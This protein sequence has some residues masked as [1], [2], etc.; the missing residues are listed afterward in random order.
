[1]T[2]H[3]TPAGNSVNAVTRHRLLV[4]LVAALGAFV[5]Q[6][7]GP[8]TVQLAMQPMKDYFRE[9]CFV[10]DVGQQLTY[11][12]NTRHPVEFNLHHHR[13]DGSMSYPVKLVVKSKHSKQ[14]IAESAELA[15]PYCFMATN[16]QDQ[17]GAFDVVINYEI[18]AR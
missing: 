13:A 6:A 10:L 7:S 2:S 9:T 8:K 16:V 18:A 3:R 14:L 5:A 1:M 11:E 4:G 12:L 15:G 17:P